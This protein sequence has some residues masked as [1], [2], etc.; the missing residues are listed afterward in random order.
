MDNY[1]LGAANDPD[2]PYNEPRPEPCRVMVSI[3]LSKEFT[4]DLIRRYDRE[5]DESDV[6]LYKYLPDEIL[7]AVAS[8][9]DNVGYMREDAADWDIDNIT[10]MEA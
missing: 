9:S 7:K 10:V 3:T 5:I 2:A 1:P 4:I 8:K 6:R